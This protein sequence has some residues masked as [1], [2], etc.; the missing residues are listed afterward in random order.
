MRGAKKRL[1]WT[2]VEQVQ[3][4]NAKVNK[5]FAAVIVG[6][7][8]LTPKQLSLFDIVGLVK[9]TQEERPI[10]KARDCADPPLPSQRS[11]VQALSTN[12]QGPGDLRQT[13][14]GWAELGESRHNRPNLQ[15]TP[16][17]PRL[18]K[19]QRTVSCG[20]LVEFSTGKNASATEVWAGRITEREEARR[21]GREGGESREQ[22]FRRPAQPPHPNPTPNSNRAIRPW[23]QQGRG[24]HWTVP[25]KG[26]LTQYRLF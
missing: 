17:T 21:T 1:N 3:K 15:P 13:M 6:M 11:R 22:Q 5:N 9:S 19:V 7:Q 18:Q 10:L 20:E 25:V 8:Q 14:Q 4:A 16:A 12:A 23:G 2:T 24:N 26:P